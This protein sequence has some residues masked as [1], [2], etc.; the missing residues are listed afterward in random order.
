MV[1]LI[2]LAKMT[3]LMVIIFLGIIAE[4]SFLMRM[5]FPAH[6]N[7]SEF[8]KN[9]GCFTLGNISSSRGNIQASNAM[10]HLKG[11][12]FFKEMEKDLEFTVFV[13]NTDLVATAQT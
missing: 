11:E 12:V 1:K 9:M 2:R 4:S 10:P 3:D 7:F 8:M 13:S 6:W 5:I